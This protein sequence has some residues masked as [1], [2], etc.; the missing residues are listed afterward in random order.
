LGRQRQTWPGGGTLRLYTISTLA[1]PPVGTKRTTPSTTVMDNHLSC[2]AQSYLHSSL[3]RHL[4]PTLPVNSMPFPQHPKCMTTLQ[5]VILLCWHQYCRC[6]VHY[7]HESISVGET[8]R[9]LVLA[10]SCWG[11]VGAA[12]TRAPA[13][14]NYDVHAL[15]REMLGS[16]GPVVQWGRLP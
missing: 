10:V 12:R 14:T 2:F 5:E 8:L 1:V 11:L 15:R 3:P 7:A 16:P 4:C 6:S 13:A 9:G